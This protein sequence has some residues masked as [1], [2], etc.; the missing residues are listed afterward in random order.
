ML[1]NAVINRTD[2]IFVLALAS[3][4]KKSETKASRGN[5]GSEKLR[6]KKSSSIWNVT[7]RIVA[8][9]L[10]RSLNDVTSWKLV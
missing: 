6:Q 5:G 9:K 4:Y 8:L 3:L 1:K 2:Y 10:A 7:M